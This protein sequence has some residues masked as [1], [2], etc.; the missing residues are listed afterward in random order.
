MRGWHGG[1]ASAGM[2]WGFATQGLFM[3]DTAASSA[4]PASSFPLTVFIGGGNMASAIV[5]GLLRH[6]A[7]AARMDI[8]EPGAQQAQRLRQQ[9]GVR[10]WADA[11]AARETLARAEL[12]VWAVKPQVFA[13]AA[14]PVAPH[15]RQALHL[16]VMAGIGADN[17]ARQLDAPRVVRAMPNTPAL[18]GCGMTGL[19]ARAQ[20]SQ[21]DRALAER[22]M[23]AAGQCL[24]VQQESLLDAVTA[25]SGSGPAYVFYFLEAMQ[26]AGVQM[27]LD[28]AQALRLATATFSGASAL[29]ERSDEPPAVL[30]ERVTSPGGT[31][32][33]ALCV[34]EQ[35][36]VAQSFEAAMHAACQRA[37]E[38]G[39][40][41]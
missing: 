31:T 5:G 12:L 34:L 8:I 35:A 32:F 30:R 20:A 38:L 17:I 6:G 21:A 26:R 2:I 23:A 40:Q 37:Q 10:V 3:S 15:T 18:V 1:T 25:L 28:A 7:Q 36:H 33:A 29:A 41:F 22:V 16:C 13:Q 24:W 14:Q 11:Q 39:S 27:G 9:F 4:S 19:F